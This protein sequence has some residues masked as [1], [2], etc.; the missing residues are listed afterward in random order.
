[1]T[2]WE[3]YTILTISSDGMWQFGDDIKEKLNKAGEQGWELVTAIP[4][5]DAMEPLFI[6]KRPMALK[7]KM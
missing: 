3:Y 5:S 2:I 1:M 7:P 6:F 4:T